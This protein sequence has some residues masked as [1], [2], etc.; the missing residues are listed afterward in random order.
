MAYPKA[1]AIK[2]TWDSSQDPRLVS[3]VFMWMSLMLILSKFRHNGYGERSASADNKG[4]DHR[5]K[6]H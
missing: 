4:L 6:C 5:G 1:V 2:D 3:S